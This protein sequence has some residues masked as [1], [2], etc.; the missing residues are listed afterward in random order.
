LRDEDVRLPGDRRRAAF[1]SASQQ[2]IVIPD[3][4]L[5]QISQLADALPG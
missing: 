1:N 2:G 4:L 5:K 3:A